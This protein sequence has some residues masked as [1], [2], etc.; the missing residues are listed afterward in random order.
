MKRIQRL[1]VLFLFLWA[2]HPVFAG[3]ILVLDRDI[4]ATFLSPETGLSENS[5]QAAMT[6][7]TAQGHTVTRCLN[8]P[9][10]LSGYDVIFVFLGF[11]GAN[12]SC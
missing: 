10:D 12:A 3:N 8:L 1:S 9:A 7:L 11:F 2:C 6:I 5:E 4:D